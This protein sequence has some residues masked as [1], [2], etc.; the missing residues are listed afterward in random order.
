MLCKCLYHGLQDLI[1]LQTFYND[2]D[3]NLRFLDRVFVRAFMSK[4][5][6]KGF[7]LI[8]E[9]LMTSY[10]WSTERFTCRAKPTT[11]NAVN[12]EDK[13]LGLNNLDLSSN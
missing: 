13:F 5:Y 3:G 1:Q 9:M 11:V 4:T 12:D 6:A 2:L 8:E 10:M 7:Q